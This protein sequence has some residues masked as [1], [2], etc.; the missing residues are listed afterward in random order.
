MAAG[1]RRGFQAAA[2]RL[3]ADIRQRDLRLGVH[4]RLD[5]RALADEHGI[6]VVPITDLIAEGANP[7][8][9]RQLTVNDRRAFSAGTVLVGT[10][11][12]IIFNPAHS[13][14]RQA[15]SLTHELAHLF[16]EHTPG[17]A[18]GPGGCRV[19]MQ[20]MENEA[21][22]LAAMLLVQRDAAL[23]CAR[24][25]LPYAIGAARFGVSADLMRWRTDHSGAS[26]QARAAASKSGRTIPRLSPAD[27]A[28]LSA[29]GDLAWL[30][31]LSAT[32]WQSLVRACGR[33]LA[34]GSFDDLVKCLKQPLG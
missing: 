20:A 9:I 13:D 30:A 2:D 26:Y 3:A 15:N 11:R 32:D 28:A 31:D 8:S 34:R 4:D 25:G 33:A 17:P 18:I 14:G 29:E 27:V 5:P 16:L 1:V 7:A 10:T 22:L 23:T 24:V 6:P 12:L 19:W 21:D